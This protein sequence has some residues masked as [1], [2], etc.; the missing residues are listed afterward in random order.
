MN[1]N[2]RRARFVYDAARLHA[3]YLGCPIVPAPWEEREDDFRAQFVELVAD[4]CSGRREF[5]D[6][7]EAHD[8]WVKGYREMGWKYGDEY[9]PEK[10][11]HPDLVP[12]DNLD[13]REKIKD[14]V[15]VRLVGIARDCI[16]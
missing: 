16:W 11:T 4:L 3:R 6:F 13:P 1:L 7:K 2:E 5:Q 15:F 9:D 8:S 12:Y 10:K 14:E